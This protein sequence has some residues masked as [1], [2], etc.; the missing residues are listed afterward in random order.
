MKR[1]VTCFL[2]LCAV[3][4]LRAETQVSI[5]T[6]ASLAAIGDKI[7]LKILV[8]TS[9]GIQ[10]IK[11][12]APDQKDFEIIAESAVQKRQEKD[13]IVFEKNMVIAFFKT[14]DFEIAPFKIDLLKEQ[15]GGETRET[16]SLPI[17][18][19]SVLQE[20]DKDIKPLK[21]LIALSG[22]P[23]YVLKYALGGLA[24]ILLII[25]VVFWLKKRKQR[26]QIA[27]TPPLPPLEEL[28]AD[29]KKL[30]E[31]KLFDKGM[32][33]L[34]FI[35]LTKILKRFLYRKYGFNAE[36]FTTFETL[37]FLK[38]EEPAVIILNNMG[39]I[40]DTADLVKFAKFDPGTNVQAEIL[41]GIDEMT[42]EYKKREVPPL[43]PTPDNAK[44]RK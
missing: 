2:F 24:V 23:F 32:K 26:S 22:N 14:G 15:R 27:E 33:K 43:P 40:F 20:G 37:Y 11:L 3:S 12:S 30:W 39:R 29:I 10:D 4:F 19:K 41:A 38:K 13:Y 5:S 35:N 9:E 21:D 31:Q 6:S 1:C 25:V 16:N 28:R 7:N 44:L 8:K 17:T 42:A 18:V 34:F 36:D